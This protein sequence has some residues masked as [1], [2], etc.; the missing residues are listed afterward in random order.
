MEEFNELELQKLI[1]FALSN[2]DSSH[3]FA[4]SGTYL[5]L[6]ETDILSLVYSRLENKMA[7]SQ[8][9]ELFHDIRNDILSRKISTNIRDLHTITK[10]CRKCKI[11]ATPE[12]PKWNVENPAKQ[13][14]CGRLPECCRQIELFAAMV[15]HMGCPQNV[16]F[17]TCTMHPV[18]AKIIQQQR[19]Y[20]GHGMTQV[21][22][23]RTKPISDQGVHHQTDQAT[24]C[25][26]ELA[27]DAHVDGSQAV[28]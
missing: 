4:N 3:P 19:A 9:T 26:R 28:F 2:T 12:L 15:H 6:A 21:P 18:I 5:G 27:H 16:D 8:M 1:D 7:I 14:S 11:D 23:E 17:M 13:K 10:N 24:N 25:F 22:C 20:P